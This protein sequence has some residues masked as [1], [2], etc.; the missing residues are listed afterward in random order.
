MRDPKARESMKRAL[1]LIRH[2]PIRRGGNGRL[3]PL[4]QLALLHALGVGWEA[5]HVITTGIPPGN[6]IPRHYKVDIA[7]AERRIA[8]ELDGASHGNRE[9]MAADTRKAVFL[10]QRGWRVLHISNA[11][12]LRLYTTYT[13]PDTLLTTLTAYLSTTAI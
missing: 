6:G 10:V 13:S 1:K 3:L 7:N 5:E 4:P 2:Q 8:I 12:A 9:I 11:I